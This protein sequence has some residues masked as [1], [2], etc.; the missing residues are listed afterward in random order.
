MRNE[1]IP[2]WRSNEFAKF[3]DEIGVILDECFAR[4]KAEKD[5]EALCRLWK[6]VLDVE[7]GFWPVV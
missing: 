4:E 6:S 3:V 7:I 2:N 1:F 5:V